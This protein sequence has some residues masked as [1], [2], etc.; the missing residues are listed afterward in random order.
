MRGWLRLLHSWV[1]VIMLVLAPLTGSAAQARQEDPALLKARNLLPKLTVEERIGQLFLVTFKGSSVDDRSQIYDLIVNHHVGGLVLLRE[2]DN[3]SD[4]GDILASTYAMISGVQQAE[5]QASQQTVVS[6]TTGVSFTPQYVPLFVGISQEG[7][8]SG[9]NQIL[10]GVTSLPSLMSIGAAWDPEL[11]RQVGQIMGR[12][13]SSLGFNLYLGPALDI[14]SSPQVATGSDLGVRSFGGS[15]Y[16]VSKMGQGY[17]RGL[18]EGSQNNL[19]VIASGFPGRG[20]ADRTSKEE[21]ATVRSSLDELKSNELAPF[22]AVTG[23]I[24]SSLNTVDGLLVSHIRYQGLQG[25]IRPSTRPFSADPTALDLVLKLPDL[26]SWRQ[27]GGLTVSDDL[28]STAVRRFFEADNGL[29]NNPQVQQTVREAFNA[30]N[31]LLYFNNLISDEDP[32]AYTTLVRILQFFAQKYRTDT[33]FA[34]RVDASVERILAAKYRLY[35]EFTVDQVVPP[36]ED[37]AQVGDNEQSQQVVMDV[38]RQSVTLIYPSANELPNVLPQPPGARSRM[39]FLTDVQQMS[40]CSGC[41]LRSPLQFDS[42]QNAVLR[43]YGPRATGQVTHSLM[44]SYAF[45][46]IA[47]MLD[48]PATDKKSALEGDLQ[49]AE[50]VVVALTRPDSEHPETQAFRR[51]LSERPEL[52]RDKKVVVFA[53]DAPYYL[54]ATDISKIT[55]YYGVYSKIG[56]FVD[57]AARMLFQ[58]L[59]PTGAL[60]VSVSGAGYDLNEA[61]APDPAQNISLTIDLTAGEMTKTLPPTPETTIAATPLLQTYG[62][63]DIIPLRTGVILDRNGRSVPDNTHVSF[64]ITVVTSSGRFQQQIEQVTRDGVARVTYRIEQP[65]VIDIYATSGGAKSDIVQL[66]VRSGESVPTIVMQPTDM[67]TPTP[68]QTVTP[69]GTPTQTVTPT[70]TPTPLPEVSVSGRDWIFMLLLTVAVAVG[71]AWVGMRQ[72][73]TRWGL[74]WGLAGLIGGL[75]A[76]NYLALK[77]PGS[78]EL[79]RRSGTGGT[80]LVTLLGVGVGLLAGLVWKFLTPHASAPD[81]PERRMG[82]GPKTGPKSNPKI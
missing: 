7:D 40:Q 26:V 15:P 65:G 3:F 50:W 74:R 45:S 13:L 59:S 67:P 60:P 46:D 44:S 82:T 4:E 66:D 48:E 43:F 68:S 16:W 57:V 36:Q 72:A 18:H 11:A 54:D 70:T 29:Y 73:I 5:W 28:G 8:A 30:G 21:I 53:F 35:P 23:D 14:L 9:Y 69:T 78:E 12:D 64:Q 47:K 22:F 63:D 39:V 77:L 33:E 80:L 58:E 17:I 10:S 55:A 2:N 32:D 71:V 76:Y 42:M 1:L 49:L 61:T 62:V 52:L 38:A 79:L 56:S 51:L 25:N 41:I 19:L 20:N 24:P 31:D 6:P 34:R 37:L 81:V 75:I 27:N